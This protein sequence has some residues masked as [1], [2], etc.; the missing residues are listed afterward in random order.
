MKFLV[1]TVGTIGDINGFLGIAQTLHA[2][3]HEVVYITNPRYEEIVRKVG[4]D[5]LPVGDADELK[6]FIDSPDFYRNSVA[7]KACMQPLFLSPMRELYEVISDSNVAGETAIVSSSWSF[8][9]RIANEKLGVPM[10]TVHL[11][12]QTVRS[13]FDTPLMPPPMV[14]SSWV[15]QFAKRLQFGSR[16][17]YLSIRSYRR[18]RTRF[19]KS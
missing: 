11:E 16:T 6:A 18:K 9:A 19:E 10:A 2:R 15:P 13:L 14:V 7:W 3:G 17:I 1:T 5:F 8:G 12:T 4:I